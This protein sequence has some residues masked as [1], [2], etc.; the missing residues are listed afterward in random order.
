MISTSWSGRPCCDSP[1][2]LE[3]ELMLLRVRHV[4]VVVVCLL[5]GRK[6][7]N[8]S[9]MRL[10]ICTLEVAS[11]FSWFSKE[12]GLMSSG[13]HFLLK[14]IPP[15]SG[16]L[17]RPLLSSWIFNDFTFIISFT[18]DNEQPLLFFHT[19]FLLLY[20]ALQHA[21]F[22]GTLQDQSQHCTARVVTVLDT[23]RIFL[24]T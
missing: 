13:V 5:L 17:S 6:W 22:P 23:K 14:L 15:V 24:P 8:M 4:W 18:A 3:R 12:V 9:R 16:L 7:K 20:S 11:S 19:L 2:S 21:A 1:G 10:V